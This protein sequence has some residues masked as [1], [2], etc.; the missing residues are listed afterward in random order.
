MIDSGAFSEVAFTSEGP[1]IVSRITRKEWKRRLGIY[2]RLAES[3]REKATLVAPDQVEIR[4]KHY[5]G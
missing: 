3:L 5:S 2:I 1:R 4:E